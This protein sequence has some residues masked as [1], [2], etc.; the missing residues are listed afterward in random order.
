MKKIGLGMLLCAVGLCFAEQPLP[1][2][3]PASL[4]RRLAREASSEKSG[5]AEKSKV[6]TKW[7]QGAHGYK[8]ALAAQAEN[9]ADV[10]V[11]FSRQSPSDEKGLCSWFEKKGLSDIKV[12]QAMRSFNRVHVALPGNPDNQRMAE[13]F[14]VSKTPACYLVWT[15]GWKRRIS[16][17]FD[18]STG[19]P[20]LRNG[21]EIASLIMSSCSASNQFHKAER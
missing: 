9:G 3:L 13:E 2:N 1:E 20:K 10:F 12:R 18:W 4:R 6:S 7:N 5:D 21:E 15:N 17:P 14:N 19:R 11:W 8:K 16:S